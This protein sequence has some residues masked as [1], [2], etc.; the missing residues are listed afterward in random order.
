VGDIVA[1]EAEAERTEDRTACEKQHFDIMSDIE[2]QGMFI[3][4]SST[5]EIRC[6][7]GMMITFGIK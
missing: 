2:C 4:P 1:L 3:C 7:R 5:I 6:S